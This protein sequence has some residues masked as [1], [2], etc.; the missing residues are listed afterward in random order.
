MESN[1]EYITDEDYR[2]FSMDFSPLPEKAAFMPAV[3]EVQEQKVSTA[4]L[5]NDLLA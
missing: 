5:I 2:N 3:F 4:D 1:I